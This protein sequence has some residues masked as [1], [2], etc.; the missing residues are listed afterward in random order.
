MQV[1]GQIGWLNASSY[2]QRILPWSN[3]FA[4]KEKGKGKAKGETRKGLDRRRSYFATKRKE[5]ERERRRLKT[6][7][8]NGKKSGERLRKAKKG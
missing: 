7:C 6:F 2:T 8:T 4:Q 3:T 5:E 1:H